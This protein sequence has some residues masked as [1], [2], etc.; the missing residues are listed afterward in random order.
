MTAQSNNQTKDQR[1]LTA[2]PSREELFDALRLRHEGR[3]V[4]FKDRSWRYIAT[5]RM[6][7][8]EDG[9]GDGWSMKGTT[10]IEPIGRPPGCGPEKPLRYHFVGYFNI[11]Q[12]KGHLTLV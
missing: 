8:G 4:I 7:E 12:R 2:G 5:I 1:D 11:A 6:I 3:T 9:S 10:V